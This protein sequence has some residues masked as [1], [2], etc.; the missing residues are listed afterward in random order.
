[1]LS[2]SISYSA[3]NAQGSRVT[4]LVCTG[5]SSEK[6]YVAAVELSGGKRKEGMKLSLSPKL[7]ENFSLGP[8]FYKFS[9]PVT[10]LMPY[11]YRNWPFS[12]LNRLTLQITL[13]YIHG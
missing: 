11:Y 8:R 2:F 10:H 12:S 4:I 1:M 6:I 3:F 7:V 5:R 13:I 9:F